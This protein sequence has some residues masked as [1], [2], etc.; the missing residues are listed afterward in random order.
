MTNPFD[1]LLMRPA[2]MSHVLLV[3]LL[4]HHGG[5]MELPVSAFETDAIAGPDGTWHAVA[6]ERQPDGAM[7]VFVHPR[8]DVDEAGIR[9]T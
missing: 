3:A 2:D 1:G 7:R 9:F 8:P 5:S 4:M 6:M